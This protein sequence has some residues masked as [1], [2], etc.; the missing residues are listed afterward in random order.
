[1]ADSMHHAPSHGTDAMHV[2]FH[3]AM[4]TSLFSEAWTPRT[5]GQYA[6]TCIALVAFTIILRILIAFKPRLEGTLWRRDGTL[7]HSAVKGDEED[8]TKQERSELNGSTHQTNMR[9]H[10]KTGSRGFLRAA[11]SA[12]GQAGYEVLIAFLGYLLML[13][14]MSMNVGYFLS[15]LLGVFLGTLGLGG[16]ARDT[17]FDHCS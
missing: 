4:S 17:T 7:G 8:A 12:T 15:V 13:A 9:K 6:G 10:R 11:W 1:M 16:I 14:V 2:V 5:S 3:T